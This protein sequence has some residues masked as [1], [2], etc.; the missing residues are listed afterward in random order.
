MSDS[1]PKFIQPLGPEIAN[2]ADFFIVIGR[3]LFIIGA[4]S[5][6]D[7]KRKAIPLPQTSEKPK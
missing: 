2:L 1:I 3:V 7:Y 6:K 4:F 5:M